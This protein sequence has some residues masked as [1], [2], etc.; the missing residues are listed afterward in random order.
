VKIVRVGVIPRVACSSVGQ[1]YRVL[2]LVRL[3]ARDLRGLLKL[4]RYLTVH[5][6]SGPQPT[7]PSWAGGLF[8][9]IPPLW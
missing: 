3:T 8:G 2:N 7:D 5:R 4:R 6:T 1:A 9:S